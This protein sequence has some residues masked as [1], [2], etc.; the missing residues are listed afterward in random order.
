MRADGKK[1]RIE[2]EEGEI[3]ILQ[4]VLPFD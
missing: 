2:E 3:K 4:E 1:G